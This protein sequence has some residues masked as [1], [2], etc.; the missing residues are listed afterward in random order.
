ML[1]CRSAIAKAVLAT[2]AFAVLP[3]SL[4]AREYPERPI[5]FV[6]PFPAGGSVDIL[7]RVIGNKLGISMGQTIVVENKPG[8]AGSIGV[9][10]AAKAPADGYTFVFSSPGAVA[11]NQNF[12]KLPYDPIKDLAPVTLIATIPTAIAVSPA[13]PVKNIKEFVA[14]AKG[15]P[16]GATF[17][18]SGSGSQ[19][20]LASELF[21]SV[22]GFPVTIVPYK[23]TQPAATAIASGEVTAGI[24]DLTTLVPLTKGDRLRV[25]AVVD[26]KRATSAPDIPTVAESGYPGFVASGWVAMFAP[27]GTPTDVV[28]KVSGEVGRALRSADVQKALTD[29]GMEAAPGTPA[30]LKT[31]LAQEITKWAKVVKDGNIKAE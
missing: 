15:R 9:D 10:N 3:C 28:T 27:A 25:L 22:A 16:E 24:S 26:A 8:A 14:Y 21:A 13:L 30:E 6:V 20:H 1:N 19:T 5:R 2:V 17:S 11:I 7:A 4:L 29:A 23:G 18:V 12:R 31:F